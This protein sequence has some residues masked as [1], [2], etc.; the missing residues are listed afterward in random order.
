MLC[1]RILIVL[2]QEIRLLTTELNKKLENNK[3]ITMMHEKTSIS[4][5]V[6][7]FNEK[8]GDRDDAQEIT[9]FWKYIIFN[10]KSLSN[11]YF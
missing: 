11:K 6:K 4:G 7:R 9:A 8:Q 1:I 2:D 3:A 10:R 5:H